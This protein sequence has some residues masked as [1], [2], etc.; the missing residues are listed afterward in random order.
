MEQAIEYLPQLLQ[1]LVLT[2]VVTLIVMVLATALGLL[3]AIGRMSRFALVR[4]PLTAYVE[5]VRGTPTLVHL[6]YVFYVLPLVGVTLPAV[7]AGVIGLTIGYA[8][9]LSEVFRAAIGSVP[10]VQQ[11]AADSLGLSKVQSFRLVI[12]PQA[13]RVAL[14]PTVNYL[15]SLFKDTSLLSIITIQELMFTGLLIGSM[16]FQYFI[17]FTEVAIL[18][19]CVCYPWA[20]LARRLEKRLSPDGGQSTSKRLA[21]TRRQLFMS[22]G[23]AGQK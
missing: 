17:I 3:V 20:W 7:L 1:G 13:T 14:P 5:F 23:M 16:T 2:V 9:Y 10:L 15:L 18:Y 11:E 6:Y 4:G 12:M 19:F 21:K 8:A 22:D